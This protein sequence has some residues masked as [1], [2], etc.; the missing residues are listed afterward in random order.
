MKNNKVWLITGASQGIGFAAVRY[1]LSKNQTV[2]ATTRDADT[3]DKN[4]IKNPLLEVIS[5]DLT[6]EENVEKAV[7]YV[8]EKYG[9]IDILI[10]NAGFG[11][12]GAIEEASEDEIAKVL[13]INV[14]A[15]IRMTR[16]VLP[17]MRKAGSGHIINL[18]S[19][20]GLVSSAGFGIYNAA[21]YAV[22]GFSEALYHEVKDLG[23]KV[24]IIEPGAF[25]TNF[26]DSSLAVA[27][28]S[29]TDYDATAGNFKNILKGN[30]GNQPGDPERAAQIILEISEMENPPLRLLLGQDAYNRVTKKLADMQAEIE[31]MKYITLLTG[32][33]NN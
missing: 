3:F 31:K 22:E 4:V 7:S 15:T 13:S 20:S 33:S 11:F 9:T 26:L 21:K 6:N 28:K 30:N 5:L 32:F 16:Y 27:K 8:S 2:I 12:V 23:I 14:E 1:L 29:I 19:A 17:V 25:R 24:T 18:S 10:N